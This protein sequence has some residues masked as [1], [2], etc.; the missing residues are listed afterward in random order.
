M[1]TVAGLKLA[2]T[3]H[4]HGV[5]LGGV[6][7]PDCGGVL[8]GRGGTL[9]GVPHLISPAPGSDLWGWTLRIVRVS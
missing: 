3:D 9:M 8:K 7:T 1:P 5:Q 4:G 6:G 2:A